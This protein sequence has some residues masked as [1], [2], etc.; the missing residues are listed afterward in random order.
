MSTATAHAA[1]AELVAKYPPRIIRTEAENNYYL[2]VLEDLDGRG[3][4]TKEERELAEVLT[5][6]VED[7]EEKH[8]AL[9]RSGPLDAVKFLLEQHGLRQ[10]DLTDVFGTESIVSEVMRGKREMNKGQ[11]AR[12]SARFGVSPELFF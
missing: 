4:L 6:L 7:F 11:I 2:N 8:Y 3:K 1:Y 10:K 5:L 12:L 9:P